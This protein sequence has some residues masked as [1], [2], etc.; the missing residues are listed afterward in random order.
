LTIAGDIII[1]A[2]SITYLG[3]FTDDYRKE[4]THSWLQELKRHNIQHS[5]NYS[6]SNVLIDP[7]ELRLW[8]VC[9]LPRDPVSTD[10][11]I[12]A[13]RASRWPLMIDPQGQAN[14][15]IKALEANNSLRT[16]RGTDSVDDLKDAI[17]DAVKLGGV[18][19]IEGINEHMS[20]ALIP[21]LENV[22]FFRVT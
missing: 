16:C 6:L 10:S 11:M 21:A 19:L 9:G 4:I 5:P 2:G 1:A 15:W 8:N 14:E 13:T 18:I 12:I 22:T 3:P 7:S 17:V 20:P